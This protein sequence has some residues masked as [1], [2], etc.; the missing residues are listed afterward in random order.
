MDFIKLLVKRTNKLLFGLLL[1]IVASFILLPKLS[2]DDYFDLKNI[3]LDMNIEKLGEKK[4]YD[5]EYNLDQ[6]RN[7][8]KDLFYFYEPL[9]ESEIEIEFQSIITYELKVIKEMHQSENLLSI[10]GYN[11]EPN[12][13]DC[14][15]NAYKTKQQILY[16]DL[17]KDMNYRIYLWDIDISSN[18]PTKWYFNKS[19][20]EIST[21]VS[22][23]IN[24]YLT[25]QIAIHDVNILDKEMFV[26]NF[27]FETWI[28]SNARK[29]C[30]L[31]TNPDVLYD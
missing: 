16:S 6:I 30:N 5:I 31:S 26:R 18:H 29:S 15:V 22:K 8:Y 7:I 19:G 25:N 2:Q 28:A 20:D 11:Y 17:M 4:V 12:N 24:K 1:I 3:I 9:S 21:I 14:F 23:D 13:S 27:K 10:H